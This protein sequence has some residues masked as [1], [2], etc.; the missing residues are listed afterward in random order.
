MWQLPA[1]QQLY[2]HLSPSP[3]ESVRKHVRRL[4]QLLHFIFMNLTILFHKNYF[5]F[6]KTLCKI[7]KNFAQFDFKKIIHKFPDIM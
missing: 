5:F 3:S 7:W 6:I 4:Y 1:A 2:Q